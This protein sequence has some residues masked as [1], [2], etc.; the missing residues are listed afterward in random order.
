MNYAQQL[1]QSISHACNCIGPQNGQPKCPCM[2][3]NVIERD[4]RY[5]QREVDL[6]PVVNPYEPETNCL[7]NGMDKTKPASLSCPCKRCSAYSLG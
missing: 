5:I 4:G 3:R 6:G 7:W 1:T 2:M